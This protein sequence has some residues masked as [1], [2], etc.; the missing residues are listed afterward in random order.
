VGPDAIRVASGY[1]P[2]KGN[3]CAGNLRYGHKSCTPVDRG[4]SVEPIER[5]GTGH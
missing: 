5:A 4:Q 2:V 3:D 1:L